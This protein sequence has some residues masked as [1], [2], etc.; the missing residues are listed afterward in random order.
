MLKSVSRALFIA[1]ML[2]AF[3][4]QTVAFNSAMSCETSENSFHTNAKAHTNINISSSDADNISE[5]TQHKD[6]VLLAESSSE[7]CCG[8]ECCDVDCNCIANACSLVMYVEIEACVTRKC[9]L[10]E[11]VCLQQADQPKAIASLLYRPPIFIS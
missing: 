4:G 8:I 6:S 7:D 11:D 3:I 10:N 2:I 1:V 9:T 5:Q